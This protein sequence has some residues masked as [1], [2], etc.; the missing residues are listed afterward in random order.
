MGVQIMSLDPWLARLSEPKEA[1]RVHEAIL[2]HAFF[3]AEL[4]FELAVA[5]CYKDS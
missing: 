3:N 5:G 1:A 4:L 2:S